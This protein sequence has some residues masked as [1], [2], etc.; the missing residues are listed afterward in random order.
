MENVLSL[1][2]E[3]PSL[4]PF[5]VEREVIKTALNNAG[6]KNIYVCADT[7]CGKTVALLSYALNKDKVCWVSVNR[8]DTFDS[9][10]E[11]LSEKLSYLKGE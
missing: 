4:P 7:G 11:I 5:F 1:K 10:K 3:M 2:A 8:Y 9:V 6:R